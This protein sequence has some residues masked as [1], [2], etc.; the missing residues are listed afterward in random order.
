MKK[1]ISLLI[2]LTL[3]LALAISVSASPK[4]TNM[5]VD[6]NGDMYF[7]GTLDY[8]AKNG[9]LYVKYGN[10]E[11]YYN[12]HSANYYHCKTYGYKFGM[13][14]KDPNEILKNYD[15]ISVQ[16][17]EKDKLDGNV[18]SDKVIIDPKN[19]PATVLERDVILNSISINGEALADFSNDTKE[20]T[21]TLPAGYL[22]YPDVE[23]VA[24][25]IYSDVEITYSDFNSDAPT[26]TITVTNG[27]LEP[28]VF[29]INFVKTPAVVTNA[30]LNDNIVTKDGAALP[31]NQNVV[32]INSVNLRDD[33]VKVWPDRPAT[34]F[35]GVPAELLGATTVRVNMDL[36]N[37]VPAD[38]SQAANG[39]MMEFKINQTADVYT[40]IQ[41]ASNFG[42]LS[43][44]GFK[45][46]DVKITLG[47]TTVTLYKKTVVVEPGTTETVS[48]GYFKGTTDA[49]VTIVKFRDTLPEAS[50]M[51]ENAKIFKKSDDS[52]I[53]NVAVL[54]NI[55]QVTFKDTTLT[56]KELYAA[57]NLVGAVK[58]FRGRDYYLYN[59]PMLNGSSYLKLGFKWSDVTSSSTE[60]YY[61]TF[62][63]TKSAKIYVNL[64]NVPGNRDNMYK[65]N[66]WLSGY[67]WIYE[68]KGFETGYI[69]TEGRLQTKGYGFVKTIEV[70]E[71]KEVKTIKVGPFMNPTST[72]NQDTFPMIYI[73]PL[74]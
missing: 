70:D 60:P 43:Q 56:G 45:L 67:D 41:N 27:D 49:P 5:F 73:Q 40:Y 4:I 26:A 30:K 72:T 65:A 32:N 18:F 24:N 37:Y 35:T 29:T 21:V 44:N 55:Q 9:G 12:I 15:E 10:K 11:K 23:C 39:N 54:N 36:K 1:L 71:G 25:K 59:S 28:N 61:C 8:E 3:V 19:N 57:S 51:I 64:W 66:P 69:D 7:F 50:G 20:Y 2:G 38:Y 63:L 16:I 62:D 46:S 42:W 53:A 17:W 58:P 74:D 14:L 22:T 34:L 33:A 31:D 6:E 68:N 48:I 13:C 47:T 52:F